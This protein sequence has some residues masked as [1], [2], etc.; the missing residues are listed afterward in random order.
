MKWMPFMPAR[1]P[2]CTAADIACDL[3]VPRPPRNNQHQE[4]SGGGNCASRA[5]KTQSSVSAAKAIARRDAGENVSD[6]TIRRLLS[7]DGGRETQLPS[8][9]GHLLPLVNHLWATNPSVFSAGFLRWIG[10]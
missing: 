6:S 9:G 10:A 7:T 5:A 8:D 1:T 3:P 2:V 4:R